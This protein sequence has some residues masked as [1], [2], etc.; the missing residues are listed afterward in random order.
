[1]SQRFK[2]APKLET[3]KWLLRNSFRGRDK[4]KK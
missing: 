3:Q 1:M 2:K 4:P